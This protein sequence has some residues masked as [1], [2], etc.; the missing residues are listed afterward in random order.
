LA[1]GS[2]RR[3]VHRT[4]LAILAL[5]GCT[6]SKRTGIT[7]V[8]ADAA[9]AVE[10]T[11]ATVPLSSC[12]IVVPDPEELGHMRA[13]DPCLGSSR[14]AC[15]TGCENDCMACGATCA[16]DGACE[17]RCL[18]ARDECKNEHCKAVH[19]S[20]RADIVSRWLADRCDDRCG[21]F[22]ACMLRCG[23]LSGPESGD[24]VGGCTKPSTPSCNVYWCDAMQ[25]APE[26]KRLDPKWAA[27]RCED[28]CARVWKCAASECQRSPGCAEDVKKYGACV[29]RVPGARGCG[30]KDSWGLCPE[31]E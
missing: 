13:L 25:N 26:R 7:T 31:P 12:R 19:S 3:R 16:R 4:A 30:L 29:E 22:R 6:P 5:V 21:P 9:D 18:R 27:N 8:A 20:C 15:W 23:T 2:A 1:R 11:E 28:V 17:A 24:C 14:E 10:T